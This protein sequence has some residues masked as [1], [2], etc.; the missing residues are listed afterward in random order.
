MKLLKPILLEIK[1]VGK[2]GEIAEVA[3]RVY[4]P[5]VGSTVVEIPAVPKKEM[6][7]FLV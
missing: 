2:G 6:V 7:E 5:F 4:E 1:T 3:V